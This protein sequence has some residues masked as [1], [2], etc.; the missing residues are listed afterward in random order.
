MLQV[1]GAEEHQAPL[2][3][4]VV[5][6]RDRI[7]PGV[8]PVDAL[9][10]QIQ[11]Q[12]VG[13]LHLVR[14]DGLAVRTVHAGALDLRGGAPIGPEHPAVHRIQRDRPR[15]LQVVPDQNLP[16]LPL[17][18]R[19]LDGVLPRVRPVY[20]VVNPIDRQTVGSGD[21]VADHDGPVVPL[22]DRGLVDPL[23]GH[24]APEDHAGAE[25]EV[26]SR[27]G[28][29]FVDDAGH[30]VVVQRDLPYVPAARE[31]QRCVSLRRLALG[32]VPGI[33]HVARLAL[34]LVRALVV[35]ADLRAAP[36][37]LALVDICK[38]TGDSREGSGG[39]WIPWQVV[40]LTS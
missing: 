26:Q 34:A 2:P 35:P 9:L 25:D 18:V 32:H 12:P 22:V 4:A 31:Q 39:E 20:V 8:H 28:V 23:I 11:S 16:H 7:Q 1:L 30:L 36:R 38:P 13:P 3:A 19:Q 33:A 29:G 14:D 5:A 40:L 24:V 27:G 21:V 15:L 17:E 37:D 6:G 10:D